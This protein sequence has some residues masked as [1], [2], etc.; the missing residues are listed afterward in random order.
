MDPAEVRRRNYLRGDDM[1][2]ELGMPYRDGNPL[3]YDSGDFRAGLEAALDAVGYDAFR[4]GS[5]PSSAQRGVHRGIGLSGYVEGT[6]IGPYEGATVRMDAT[7]RASWRRAPSSSGQGHET[8]VRPGRRRRARDPA[9]VGD[10]HRRRH[11]GH[12][13]RHRD[14]REPERRERGQLDPRRAAGRVRDKLVAPRRR[15]CWRRPRRTSR[16]RTGMASVRGTPDSAV[17]LAP[18]D[19]GR[20]A[21]LRQAGR[22]VARLRGHGLSSPADRHLHERRAR[23]VRRGGRGHGRGAPPAL[24]RRPRLRQAHQSR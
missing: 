4:A 21:H 3:V 17:P 24:P 2:Y 13:L 22:G 19:P 15:R 1:P 23:R 6:A 10:R 14:L 11:R 20:D 9:R 8:S 18:G 16:S 12:P 5:R 7:G